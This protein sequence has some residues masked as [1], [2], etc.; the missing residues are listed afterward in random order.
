M[1]PTKL[2]VGETYH[3]I[4]KIKLIETISGNA[5][6]GDIISYRQLGPP[7]MDTLQ[8]KVKKGDTCVLILKYFQYID[9]YMATAFE[10]SVF[11]VDGK[12]RL[13]SM[14]NQ[15]FC[16]RYDGIG[17]NILVEDAI[18]KQE[19]VSKSLSKD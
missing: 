5:P 1:I 2:D 13:T 9:Q 3:T 7:D 11:F 6:S 14:S 4:A 15:V 19:R 18:E 12:N 10:E 16:A 17:L 8:T